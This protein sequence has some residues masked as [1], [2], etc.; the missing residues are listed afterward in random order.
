MLEILNFHGIGQFVLAAHSSVTLI[1]LSLN[2]STNPMV[3]YGTI[4]ATHLLHCPQVSTKIHSLVLIDPIAFLLHLPN[5]AYNFTSRPPRLANEHQL[6]Y[7]ASTD[8]GISHTIC[9]HFFWTQNILWKE[10]LKGKKCAV[11]LGRRDLLVNTE[12]IWEYL[13]GEEAAGD[14]DRVWGAGEELAVL[15][16]AECDHAQVFDTRE[17]RRRLVGAVREFSG[18]RRTTE[19]GTL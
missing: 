10:E 8:P 7:F 1:F 12:R 19:Y 17:R 4:L 9:R 6:E 13:T 16:Y 11:A 14:A 3:R 15:W 2:L 18:G 5:V